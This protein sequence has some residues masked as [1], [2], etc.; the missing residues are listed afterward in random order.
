MKYGKFVAEENVQL[1]ENEIN[2]FV[3]YFMDLVTKYDLPLKMVYNENNSTNNEY[4]IYMESTSEI[5][6][7]NLLK[8][9]VTSFKCITIHIRKRIGYIDATDWSK[10]TQSI[11]KDYYNAPDYQYVINIEIDGTIIPYRKRN[12]EKMFVKGA[13]QYGTDYSDFDY[14]D[15]FATL[16]NHLT[17]K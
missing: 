1:S 7:R 11:V 4:N 13:Y 14:N 15:L 8:D 10:P 2:Y 16:R 17:I 5:I 12:E 6:G 3:N 9:R